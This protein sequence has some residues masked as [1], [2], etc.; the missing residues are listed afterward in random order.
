MAPLRMLLTCAL[1]AGVLI[2]LAEPAAAVDSCAS[3]YNYCYD[4]SGTKLTCCVS[5]C[6]NCDLATG[7][8]PTSLASGE[9]QMIV[10]FI[11]SPNHHPSSQSF[12]RG[13][14]GT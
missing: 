5:T 13:R 4:A 9:F 14:C 2:S 3:G 7:L 11:C 6:D 10:K 8:P 12:Q 1:L